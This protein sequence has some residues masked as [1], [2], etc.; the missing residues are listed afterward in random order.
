MNTKDNQIINLFKEGK[1]EQAFR[2]LYKYYSRIE[3]LIL[4]QGGQKA[5]AQDIFQEALIIFYRNLE[6]SKFKL[7]ASCYTYLYAVSRYVWSDLRKKNIKNL[8]DL[9]KDITD[10]EQQIQKEKQYQKAESAFLKLGQRCQELLSLFY[11]KKQR[12]KAIAEQMQFSSEKI[13]KNQKYKC[14]Q[15]AKAYYQ[16]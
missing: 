15:K 10:L 6:K 11:I 3:K 1:R 2:R 12:L 16:S 8:P 14:L 4:K 13:A 7:T 5:D 9:P